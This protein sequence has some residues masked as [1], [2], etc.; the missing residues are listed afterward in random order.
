LVG[1]KNRG[2][3]PV[4]SK[5][6]T[7]RTIPTLNDWDTNDWGLRYKLYEPDRDTKNCFAGVQPQV[8]VL[9]HGHATAAAAQ[10][11]HV[12]CIVPATLSLSMIIDNELFLTFV[13]STL[14]RQRQN[15]W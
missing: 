12:I 13:H 10:L 5:T 7:I 6:L 4:K 14:V 9:A 1:R 3:G 8:C 11:A 15:K 2:S